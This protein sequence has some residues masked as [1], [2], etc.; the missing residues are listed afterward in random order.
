M[1]SVAATSDA[2]RVSHID[3]GERFARRIGN[4]APVAF[5]SVN[6]QKIEYSVGPTDLLRFPR[7]ASNGEI[8]AVVGGL[9]RVDRAIVPT[10]DADRR[11]IRIEI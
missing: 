7:L 8:A 11:A 9:V 2:P 10:H 5:G 4:F 1:T 3:V 6:D